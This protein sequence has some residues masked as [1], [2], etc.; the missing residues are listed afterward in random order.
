MFV[1]PTV[2]LYKHWGI[3]KHFQSESGGV[4]VTALSSHVLVWVKGNCLSFICSNMEILRAGWAGRYFLW[5]TKKELYLISFGQCLL[6]FLF[7]CFVH[8]WSS[9]D[10]SL[11]H[12][13]RP[14]VEMHVSMSICRCKIPP[15]EENILLGMASPGSPL[16]IL[17]LWMMHRML[18]MIYDA[19][20]LSSTRIKLASSS[21]DQKGDWSVCPLRAKGIRRMF[22][23]TLEWVSVQRT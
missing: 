19:G 2:C 5:L 6:T 22:S 16:V 8:A 17:R 21:W 1:C 7:S 18:A 15:S 13:H 10:R 14:A 4:E 11:S 20:S 12:P 23:R 3:W 9:M